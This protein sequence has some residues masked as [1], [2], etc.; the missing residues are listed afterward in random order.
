MKMF[1]NI[2]RYGLWACLFI[3]PFVPLYVA[4][5]M[6]F[7]FITGK[8]FL[9]RALV[10][11]RQKHYGV[12]DR[13]PVWSEAAC[14]SVCSEAH[15]IIKTLESERNEAVLITVLGIIAF[16]TGFLIAIPPSLPIVVASAGE[17]ATGASVAGLGGLAALKGLFGYPHAG[18]RR[19][20]RIAEN[21]TA[22]L[23]GIDQR[24]CFKKQ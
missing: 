1:K 15:N 13:E 7:P 18:R 11:V 8:N 23:E 5:S 16:V 22:F 6:F 20:G 17:V 14:E 3:V 9:F 24:T 12:E 2:L 19:L 4:N 21:T 10:L